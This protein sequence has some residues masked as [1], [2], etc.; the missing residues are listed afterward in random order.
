[1]WILVLVAKARTRSFN[2]IQAWCRSGADYFLLDQWREQCDYGR[3]R[4]RS[5]KMAGKYRPGAI[6]IERTGSG[7]ALISDLRK[8]RWNVVEIFPSESKLE[9]FRAVAG[10]FRAGRVSL[11]EHAEWRADFVDELVSFPT[12]SN[13]DQAD[14]AAQALRWLMDNPAVAKPPV[15]AMIAMANRGN[16]GS[17]T[18]V[19]GGVLA[20]GRSVT[21][22]FS[23]HQISNG[24]FIQPKV[25]VR[26]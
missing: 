11:F 23:D 13:D 6:L 16:A 22:A 1:M 7:A 24:P 8:R 18:E 12:G 3:L 25:T 26:Y 14:A 4:E 17:T 15:P 2:V 9:R 21:G 19:P 10:I 5:L 20:R